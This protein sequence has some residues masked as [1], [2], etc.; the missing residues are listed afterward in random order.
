MEEVK[1]YK[2]V[3]LENK[4]PASKFYNPR[5]K[6]LD[7][8]D[9]S[10]IAGQFIVLKVSESKLNAYSI[11]TP[12]SY[13]PEFELLVD[14]T[15]MGLGT[16]LIKGLKEE[17]GISFTGP[18]GHFVVQD[19]GA[20]TLIFVATGSG[21]SALRPMIE[22]LL[23][24]KDPRKLILYHGLRF[25][26]DVFWKELFEDWQAKNQNF[27]YNLCLSRPNPS[28]KGRLGRVTQAIEQDGVANPASS[29]AYLCGNGAMIQ[30]AKELLVKLGLAQD[31]I[32]FEQYFEDRKLN[33]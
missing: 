9:F 24:K 21:I 2:A 8:G 20:Q 23:G 29:A 5:F 15:P 12:L 14:I 31:K 30:D 26:E 4:N 27:I 1:F 19:D 11:A 16:Q 10:F 32:Y 17:D 33:V 13:L 25:E 18:G 6:I 22:D 3:V 28:W 7:G